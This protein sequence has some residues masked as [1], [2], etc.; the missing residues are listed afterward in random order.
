MGRAYHQGAHLNYKV[1]SNRGT[2]QKNR[3]DGVRWW[4]W[5][6]RKMEV[7]KLQFAVCRGWICSPIVSIVKMDYTVHCKLKHT[8]DVMNCYIKCG[9]NAQQSTQLIRMTPWKKFHMPTVD[10]W[11]NKNNTFYFVYIVKEFLWK[12][13]L[14]CWK[15]NK[16][17]FLIIDSK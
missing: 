4:E 5:M 7:Q 2:T 13:F 9:L 15:M 6:C 8:N 12:Y 11:Q 10:V 1:M 17:F 16:T 14:K 3:Y